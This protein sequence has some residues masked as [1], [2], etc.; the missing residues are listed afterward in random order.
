MFVFSVF[1][2]WAR[3]SSSWS[4]HGFS[5]F[6]VYSNFHGQELETIVKTKN[7][8]EFLVLRDSWKTRFFIVKAQVSLFFVCTRVLMD[9]VPLDS[10]MCRYMRVTPYTYIYIHICI[11]T[12]LKTISSYAGT[13]PEPPSP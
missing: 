4:G 10:N 5:C 11:Y 8:R 12:P 3:F 13:L 1:V 7:S 9:Q 6:F 2:V